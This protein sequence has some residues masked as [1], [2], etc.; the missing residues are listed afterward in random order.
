VTG[1]DFRPLERHDL[2]T[3]AAL[4]SRS[5]ADPPATD[6]LERTL[7]APDQP[8]TLAG[9]PDVGLVGT[10]AGVAEAGT[11]DQGFVRI[12][13]V[14]PEHRGRGVGRA[15]LAAAEQ[16]LRSRGLTS[17]GIGADAPYYL[18][19]GVEAAETAL[20]CLLERARYTRTNANFNMDV[21]LTA[22]PDDPGGWTVAVASDR[23]EVERWAA[24]HWRNWRAEMLRALDRDTLVLGR[25][26]D[27]IAAACAYDVNR[28]GWVGPVAVRPDRLGRGMGVAPLLGALHRMRAGGRTRAEVAWV[29][30]VVPYARVGATVGRVFFTHR[31][32]L[33]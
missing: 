15:L 22:I 19:P 16:D 20:L 8:V 11:A 33:A 24:M 32:E 13:V 2:P 6:E 14:A 4:C 9:D 21:D 1:N 5:L 31:K 29:G 25:D 10:C 30:P 28:G 12:L 18:W 3:I 7:F 23:D 17:A 26:A 27:G